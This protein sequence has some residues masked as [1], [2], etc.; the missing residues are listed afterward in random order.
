M[1]FDSALIDQ[2]RSGGPALE[3][4][5]TALWPQAFRLALAILRDRSAAEDA[6]Q[7]ACA[8]IASSLPLLRRPDGF[9]TWS[10]RIIVRQAIT[11]S[12]RRKTVEAFEASLPPGLSREQS[13]TIDLYN[14]LHALPARQRAA[15]ILHYYAG[16]TSAEIAAATGLPASTIRFHLMHARRALRKS[17]SDAAAVTGVSQE[18]VTHVH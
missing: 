18:A 10:Y 6:A 14:A 15:V 1:T 12:R 5:I 3:E 2:A 16:F 11:V 9:A 13:D 4:L 17:L 7:E 8:K